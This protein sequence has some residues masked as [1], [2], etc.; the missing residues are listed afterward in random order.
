MTALSSTGNFSKFGTYFLYKLRT[1]RPMIILNGIFALLSYPLAFGI[2]TAGAVTSKQQNELFAKYSENMSYSQIAELPEYVKLESTLELLGGLMIMAV[3]IGVMMLVGMFIMSYVM[4]FRSFRWLYKKTVVDM[5]YSLPVSDDTRFFGGLLASFAGSFVPHLISIGIGLIL[6]NVILGMFPDS[7]AMDFY[8]VND[9]MGQM[10]FT[11]L[12]SCFMFMAFSLFV[13]SFCG[14]TAEAGLYP[15]VITGIVPIIHAVCVEIVLSNV[16]G[17]SGSGLM[18]EISSVAATSPLGM[19]FVSISYL[20]QGVSVAEEFTAPLF[21][22]EI[23]ITAIVL[24]V[25]LFVAAYFLIRYRRTERVGSPFV[26]KAVR[27]AFPAVV[28]FAVVSAF[29]LVILQISK[30]AKEYEELGFSYSSRPEGYVVAM[31]IITFV[32]YVIMELISGKGFKKFYITLA[33]YA[34]TTGAS[35]LICVGLF[36]SNGFGMA[37]YVPAVENVQMVTFAV[38]NNLSGSYFNSKV[39]E[40]ENIEKI[41]EL[42]KNTPKHEEDDISSNYRVK[43]TYNLKDG[44]SVSRYY[45]LNRE[46]WL[47]YIEGTFT[48]EAVYRNLIETQMEKSGGDILS[49][50]FGDNDEAVYM[51]LPMSEFCEA[52]RKD[53]ENIGTY[54]D[55]YSGAGVI[56]YNIN[57][58]YR[59]VDENMIADGIERTT[60]DWIEVYSWQKNT[61]ALLKEYGVKGFDGVKLSDYESAFLVEYNMGESFM[62]YGHADPMICFIE[63]GDKSLDENTLM[64]YGYF[65]GYEFVAP[66]TGVEGSDIIDYESMSSY[67][68][69]DYE[70]R[71]DTISYRVARLDIGSAKTQEL[72]GYSGAT[73]PSDYV[74]DKC[75]GLLLVKAP[76]ALSYYYGLG[77]ESIAKELFLSQDGFAVAEEIFA[78]HND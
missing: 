24:T 59:Y 8:I 15:F 63:S 5:D 16:Y 55:T 51:K 48:P 69:Q 44:T 29:A 39:S 78:D 18:S 3:V 10:M 52:V 17:Y 72:L 13:I 50:T 60:F 38:D 71:P 30:Q 49:V 23:G 33:K 61:I 1:L 6:W 34:V 7:R 75:Y 56:R 14:R 11:G 4:C 21:R 76:D 36:N 35:F 70:Y 58:Q 74:G 73:L 45:N 25:L 54:H 47:E 53:C 12:F 68:N 19:L 27:P 77:N 41:I 42:H 9:V 62:Q 22:P 37:D 67:V 20:F 2:L 26:Y 43:I 65:T 46:R 32:L 66:E 31:I 40:R 28:T 64:E 57:V